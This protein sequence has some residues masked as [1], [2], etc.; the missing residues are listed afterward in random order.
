MPSDRVCWGIPGGGKTTFGIGLAREWFGGNVSP[1]KVAYLAFTKAAARTA[2]SRIRGEGDEEFDRYPLFRTIH[3]L[4]YRGLLR[5]NP[6]ARV[7][8]TGDL[9]QF[10]KETGLEG[11][12]TVY[13][14]EDLADVYKKLENQGRSEWD[15]A[16]T[17][18][19]LSR[20]MATSK[21]DLEAARHAPAHFA[22][23]AVGFIENDA[24]ETFVQKYEE[25]KKRDG[26]VDFTD[27]L[28]WGLLHMPPVQA[29]YVV[30]DEAQDLCPLHYSIVD[31]LFEGSEERWWIGD[32]D[33]ALYKFAGASAELFLEKT[34]RAQFQVELRQTRRYGQEVVDFS[35][36]I[37][38]RAANRH[39]KS[40]LGAMGRPGSVVLSGQFR[41][42][43]GNIFV[44]HRHVAGCQA[45]A[46]A[47]IQA[48][49]PFRNERGQNPLGATNKI[50]A[51]RALAVLAQ[52]LKAP[53]QQVQVLVEDHLPSIQKD[54]R[55]TRFVVVGAKKK[56]AISYDEGAAVSLADLVKGGILTE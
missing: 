20:V 35:R 1:D 39:E 48:G 43:P 34:R 24:Y 10:A 27:M 30:V 33:Q 52:S 32:D 38:R 54:E 18:Y 50:K 31:R 14:W 9:K 13:E 23:Q 41:P 6:D 26:L 53:V 11:A 55:R 36:Q 4:C 3:S 49:I 12:Y 45:V 8:T 28:E 42:V 22:C 5:G 40:I 2:A 7:I 25:F 21:E 17:A 46:D 37:I 47:Y 16:L 15:Q 56:L 44:L 51:W 29:Q 19:S